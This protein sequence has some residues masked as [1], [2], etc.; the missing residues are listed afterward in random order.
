MPR[1]ASATM[2]L[3]SPGIALSA[4]TR[5]TARRADW[6]TSAG[7]APRRGLGFRPLDAPRRPPLRGFHTEGAAQASPGLSSRSERRPG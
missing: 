3:V 4:S 5:R 1:I 2:R 7:C 6:R